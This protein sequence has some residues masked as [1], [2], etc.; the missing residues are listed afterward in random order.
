MKKLL[1]LQKAIGA[2]AKDSKNPFFKSNYFDI[3]KLIQ[4]VKPELNKLGLVLLQPLSHIEGHSAIKTLLIDTESGETIEDITPLPTNADPQ[5]MGSAITYYRRYALQSLLF[6]QAADD[7]ANLAS[8]KS[9]T[10]VAAPPAPKYSEGGKGQCKSCGANMVMNPKT[11]KI[12]C[13]KK[14][15]LNPPVSKTVDQEVEKIIDESLPF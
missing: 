2:I 1:E 15:W 12:F 11:S 7:D 10:G 4:E 3:N 8:G 14:C 13:E 5:K 9:L 6:L